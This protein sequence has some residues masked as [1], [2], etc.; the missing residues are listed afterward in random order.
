MWMVI[1][2]AMFL[3]NFF[4]A[5]LSTTLFQFLCHMACMAALLVCITVHHMETR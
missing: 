4:G 5:A 2:I 1:L 3:A